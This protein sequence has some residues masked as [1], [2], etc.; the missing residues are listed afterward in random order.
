[1]GDVLAHFVTGNYTRNSTYLEDGE[2]G[3]ALDCFVKGAWS[4]SGCERCVVEWK[5]PTAAGS[6]DEQHVVLC[7]SAMKANPNRYTSTGCADILVQ[8]GVSG[9]VRLTART[10]T[11]IQSCPCT[12]ATCADA[13]LQS[14]AHY[15]ITI[16]P[17]HYC[18]SC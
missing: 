14:C 2:Y 17:T 11:A 9:E 8:D 6:H 12:A 3:R 15:P 7:T 16:T 1:M 18:S 4:S 5:P 13:A 10:A